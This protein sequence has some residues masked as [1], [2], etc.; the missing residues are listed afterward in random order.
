LRGR[1]WF[2]SSLI[3]KAIASIG[4]VPDDHVV[5]DVKFAG[6]HAACKRRRRQQY[7]RQISENCTT[8]ASRAL[9]YRPHAIFL[10]R[11]DGSDITQIE[12]ILPRRSSNNDSTNRCGNEAG[13]RGHVA[14]A[15][16]GER[17][18]RYQRRNHKL[19]G[20]A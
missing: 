9:F 20:I 17:F 18:C 3:D 6:V 7:R 10:L 19:R 1:N 12:G 16:S 15:S 14:T 13:Y 4:A 5:A 2:A 8:S 11:S